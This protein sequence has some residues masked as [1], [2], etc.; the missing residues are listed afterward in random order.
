MSSCDSGLY[1]ARN[2]RHAGITTCNI[3]E[4]Q[5]MHRTRTVRKGDF[6][7]Y[8]LFT[9]S[10]LLLQRDLT[11]QNVFIFTA[12]GVAQCDGH[13]TYP[14]HHKSVDYNFLSFGSVEFISSHVK[15]EFRLRRC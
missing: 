7:F 12:A 13:K 6:F 14:V 2:H 3:D 10:L 5:Q 8:I 15:I 4:P 1:I 9:L 11:N